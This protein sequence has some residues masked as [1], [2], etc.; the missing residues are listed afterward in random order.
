MFVR[1]YDSSKWKFISLID[2]QRA[3]RIS[4]SNSAFAETR[5]YQTVLE[6]FGT[7]ENFYNYMDK[8]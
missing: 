5:S 1:E 2:W 3:E 8:N 4:G 7:V 6:Q